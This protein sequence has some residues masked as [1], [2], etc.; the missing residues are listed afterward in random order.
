[1]DISDYVKGFVVAGAAAAALSCTTGV[2]SATPEEPQNDLSAFSTAVNYG[3]NVNGWDVYIHNESWLDAG[4]KT[5]HYVPGLF[6][7]V[8]QV[9][10]DEIYPQSVGRLRG[11]RSSFGKFPADTDITFESH[12][13]WNLGFHATIRTALDG[14]PILECPRPAPGSGRY[15]GGCEI[16]QEQNRPDMPIHIYVH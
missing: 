13:M 14:T 6:D 11:F 9:Y 3:D 8:R 1:M 15:N 7:N 10:N 4:G 16:K 5:L 2:A 12:T